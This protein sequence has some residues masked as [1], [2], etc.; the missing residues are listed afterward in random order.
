L[1]KKNGKKVLF[2]A[3]DGSSGCEYEFKTK[4]ELAKLVKEYVEDLVEYE[5][6]LD[7]IEESED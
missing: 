7:E 1:V 6:D 2:I 3:N 5:V 4:K